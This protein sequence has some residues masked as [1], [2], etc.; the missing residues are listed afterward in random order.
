M[1][2]LEIDQYHREKA[3]HDFLEDMRYAMKIECDRCHQEFDQDEVECT[4]EDRVYCTD[5]FGFLEA[6][7]EMEYQ[8]QKGEE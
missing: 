1:D 2:I 5:C 8:R 4:G 7:A 3:E 6:R